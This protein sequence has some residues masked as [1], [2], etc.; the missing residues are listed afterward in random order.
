MSSRMLVSVFGAVLLGSAGAPAAANTIFVGPGCTPVQAVAAA[1]SDSPVG[2]CPAGSGAD[3]IVLEPGALYTLNAVDNDEPNG[4]GPNALPAVTTP[5]VVVGN[6]AVIERAAAGPEFRFFEVRGAFPDA[7]ALRLENLTLRG[8]RI[9]SH[10]AHTPFCAGGGAIRARG[11]GETPLE[12]D[13]VTLIGNEVRADAGPEWLCFG[14]G[15]LFAWS[16]PV[17]ISSSSLL[18]NVSVVDGGAIQAFSAVVL[19]YDSVVDG[20]QALVAGEFEASGGGMAISGGHLESRRSLISRNVGEAT[21]GIWI[22]GEEASLIANTT[23][24][25][26]LAT[27]VDP[28]SGLVAVGG[29]NTNT[30]DLVLVNNTIAANFANGEPAVGGLYVRDPTF[31]ANTIV[32]GNWAGGSETHPS[33]DCSEDAPGKISPASHHNLFGIATGCPQGGATDVLVDPLFVFAD[34]G[35]LHGLHLN[36]PGT[37]ETHALPVESPARE[38]A[39]AATCAADPVNGVDQRGV[40]R[41]G[42]PGCDIGAFEAAAPP[43]GNPPVAADDNYGTDEDLNLAV[44]A[45]AG[46]LANDFDPD[47][48]PF[49]AVLETPPANGLLVLSQD[50][51]FTYAPN[52]DFN[53]VDVFTYRAE[54]AGG[55]LSNIATVTIA[56]AG[57]N[58]PPVAADDVY[59]V[60]KDTTLN[61]A[62]P[63]VLDNDTDIDNPA[64]TTVLVTGPA[65]GALVLDPDGS[66]TYTPV[67]GFVGT[68]S[69]NYRADDGLLSSNTATVNVVVA[70]FIMAP[71]AG[72]TTPIPGGIG[73][74]TGFPEGAGASGSGA[75]AFLGTGSGGQQGVY[76]RWEGAS[77]PIAMADLTTPIPGGS[78]SFTELRDLRFS[79]IPGD[80]CR[81]AAAIGSGPGGQQGVYLFTS[82]EV[83]PSNLPALRL[84]DL[85]TSIPDG[86]GTFTGV[87]DLALRAIPTDPIREAAFIGEGVGQLGVYVAFASRTGQPAPPPIAIA[88]LGTSIPGGSDTFTALREPSLSF[89]PTDPI[90]EVAFVGDGSGGQQGIYG[91]SFSDNSGSGAIVALADR[92]TPIPGGN[93]AFTALREPSL[94]FIPGDPC[95]EAAF[96]GDG[97]GGQQGIYATTFGNEACSGA[98]TRVADCTTAIPE[99]QGTFTSFLALSTSKGH[100][101][102]LA[103]GA[104]GQKGIYLASTLT[105][106]VDLSDTIE[107]SPLA[108]LRL[109]PDGLAGNR[110]VFV[111]LFSDGSEGV[112]RVTID[113][114]D[115]NDAPVASPDGFTVDEDD[116]LSVA[117]PGVLSN[118]L[119]P[120]GGALAAMVVST[121]AHGAVAL[122][123][124][125]SFTYTPN[126]DFNGSD[127]FTYTAT[128]P[129][130]AESNVATVLITIAPVNDAPVAANDSYTTTQDT[131][132]IVPA[133]GVLGNDADAEG[134]ALAAVLAAD[135]ANGTVSLNSDGSFTYTPNPGFAGNDSFTYQATDGQATSGAAVVDIVVQAG[136]DP[137]W[138]PTGSLKVAR[139]AHTAT[140]LPSGKVLVAGGYNLSGTL[141]SAELYDPATGTWSTTGNLQAGRTGH[142]AVLL[143]SGKVLVMGGLG[144]S[145]LLKSAE[146]YNPATGTW[147]AT[148]NLKTARA[149]HT[150]AL[151]SDGKVLV[152]GGLG[153]LG[154]LKS[155]ELYDPATG[156]WSATGNMVVARTSHSMSFLTDGQVLVAGGLGNS[157]LLKGA[158]RYNPVT[159]KWTAT[160]SLGTASALHTATRLADGRVLLAGGL[161]T[162]GSLGRTERYDPSAG[163]WTPVG[164]LAVARSL[165][166]ATALPDGRVLVAGG[167]GGNLQSLKSAELFDPASA[168]WSATASLGTAR[169]RHSATLLPSG[170]VLAA[171][172][173]GA[174]LASAEL[175]VP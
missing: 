170:Q 171:G 123:A 150:A 47:G 75:V 169:D 88:D 35:V 41:P 37:T 129:G 96:I 85:G 39:D 172:G 61:V 173:G 116:T 44:D 105:K 119:D 19:L 162:T 142:T 28:A 125:G 86:A 117:A 114:P 161:G 89:I 121:P 18:D 3:T 158:E 79:A 14:G 153:L 154:I 34:N 126:A 8:G 112:F 152:A 11:N 122:A 145:G 30:T 140:P 100:T 49:T 26:N 81:D 67:N 1:N 143:P 131:P 17:S 92:S 62:A 168:Q 113:F 95:H 71:I 38:V 23:I 101:A 133:P 27:G 163:T 65:N 124:D 146:V 12:L 148:G 73:T 66:F 22:N 10:Y 109:G 63:G 56:V 160:G 40:A 157:G 104:G 29:L 175:F 24:S 9:Q 115:V 21:G 69:F 64:L 87:S 68:D 120:E 50:G 135:P 72:F 97:A 134:G 174:G 78:G 103:T 36:L 15:A 16:L 138:T 156:T 33:A 70:G 147:N 98:V 43:A 82:C 6:G 91:A 90:H 80:P 48:D 106:V 57:V 137:V 83:G 55:A 159:A 139:T 111:A 74:F 7:G 53:G 118:D 149:G 52:A 102:F 46:V 108:D 110:L 20:N 107:G 13:H 132:L 76:A 25:N 2:G 127:S 166:T 60:A 51:S 165:H 136:S 45:V 155:A 31:I 167:L 54:D 128:D 42:G 59:A 4:S 93:G 77:S 151:M 141:K 164:G 84:A 99:G 32:A 144:P 5:I 94:S 130:G 58:D